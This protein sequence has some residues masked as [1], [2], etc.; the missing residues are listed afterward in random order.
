M[1]ICTL[2]GK[3]Y[4]SV[5][6][7]TSSALDYLQR[8]FLTFIFQG[9]TYRKAQGLCVWLLLEQNERLVLL[10]VP[11]GLLTLH[12]SSLSPVHAFPSVI[13]ALGMYY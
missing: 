10:Q 2:C 12:F 13:L 4:N 3:A 6:A 5:K 8:R 1:K 9:S 11:V 7:E